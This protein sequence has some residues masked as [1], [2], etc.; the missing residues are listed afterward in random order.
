MQPCYA[1]RR[2]S[3][4][5]GF[6]ALDVFAVAVEGR[7][8]YFAFALGFLVVVG[9]DKAQSRY[10]SMKLPDQLDAVNAEETIAKP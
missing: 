1:Y 10:P 9:S 5:A 4:F 2:G 3:R 8:G 7:P 6:C